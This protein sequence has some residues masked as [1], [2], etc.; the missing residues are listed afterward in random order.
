VSRA[1]I[2]LGANLDDPLRHVR[3]ALDDLD[4]LPG[5]GVVACSSFYR[6]APLGP[7]GQPHYINAVA[8]LETALEPEAL[9]S[10][11]QS[12]ENAH[13]RVRGG[14]RWG[15]RTLD[16]DLL[17]YDRREIDTPRLRVPHPEMG[18]RNFVLAPLLE[19]APEIDIPGLGPAAPIQAR[20]G[21]TGLE[22]L[23]DGR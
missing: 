5:T 14:E 15:A 18:R 19:I 16:L 3:T 1:F 6:S 10:A 13:G 8:E 2:G 23:A 7:P 11:L 12:I 21:S 4:R 17:L 22:R 9:L 20:L